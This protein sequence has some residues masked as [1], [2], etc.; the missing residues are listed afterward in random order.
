MKIIARDLYYE[1]IEVGDEFETATRTISE[2]DVM[3]FAGLTGDFNELH[4]S[5]TFAT[6]HTSFGE[7]IAHG[8][9]TLAIANGLYMCL[10]YFNNSTVAFLGIQDW[11]FLKP[12]FLGDTVR[13]RLT[14]KDKR[15]TKKGD[16]GVI[17]WQTDVINQSDEII[18]SGVMAKMFKNNATA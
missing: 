17:Y 7:R 4:T 11:K 12:V 8:M 10:G 2:A 15:L 14:L 9:L 16:R 5:R 1:D 6:D 13:V 3:Q 18:A